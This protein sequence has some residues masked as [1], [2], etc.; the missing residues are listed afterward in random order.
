MKK[1]SPS[2]Q[3][4]FLN[5]ALLIATILIAAVVA[6]H[7]MRVAELKGCLRSTPERRAQM[8]CSEVMQ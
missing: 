5:A 2:K 3:N 6:D 1:V 7:V 8:L 4:T